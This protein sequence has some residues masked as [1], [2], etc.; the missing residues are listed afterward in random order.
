MSVVAELFRVTQTLYE[1]L[2]EPVAKENRDETIETIEQLLSQR[3][4][5]IKQLKP[6]YTDEEQEMGMAIVSLNET[7]NQKLQQLKQHIQQ[8]LKAAKQKK[9]ANQ[10]YANPYQTI[11]IDGMFYDKKS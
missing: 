6:P 2:S 11:S 3:D 1:L 9:I 10:N 8:D 7:I 5:L 4:G